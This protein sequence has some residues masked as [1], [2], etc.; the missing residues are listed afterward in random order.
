[1]F[2]PVVCS[3]ADEDKCRVGILPVTVEKANDI[4]KHCAAITGMINLVLPMCM[5]SFRCLPGG[6]QGLA[7]RGPARQLQST[8]V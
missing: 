8:Q 1:M 4:S 6:P 7:A 2:Q 3:A 5:P